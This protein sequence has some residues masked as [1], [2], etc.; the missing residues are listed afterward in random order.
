MV[1]K[2]HTDFELVVVGGTHQMFIGHKPYD[3]VI[4][5]IG[6]VMALDPKS[7]FYVPTLPIKARMIAYRGYSYLKG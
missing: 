7:G 3:I 6:G 1:E 4:D 2:T 5:E